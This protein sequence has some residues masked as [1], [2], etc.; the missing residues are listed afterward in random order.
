MTLSSSRSSS[1]FVF[2][3]IVSC[4]WLLFVLSVSTVYQ[5]VDFG[6]LIDRKVEKKNKN[7]NIK[8]NPLT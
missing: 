2:K 7:K 5:Q 3:W 4:K 8:K 6:N 1:A